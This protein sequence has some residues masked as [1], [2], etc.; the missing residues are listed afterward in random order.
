MIVDLFNQILFVPIF[1][2]LVWL[3][4]I[5]PG[6]DFGVAIIVLTL[7][8]R[9]L[10]Y[11]LAQKGIRS[12]KALSELQPQIKTVQQKYKNSKEKQAQELM[13]LYKERGVNPASGCLPLII[14]FP[15]LIALFQVLRRGLNPETLQFLYPLVQNPQT[16]NPMFLGLINLAVGSIFL[17]VLAGLTQFVQSKMILPKKIPGQQTGRSDFASMMSKQMVYTMPVITV[18]I[19]A[20]FPAGLALYWTV[21]N[22]FTIFQQYLIIKKKKNGE[23]P[24]KTN[25]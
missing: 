14:Q 25:N 13:K 6:G 23:S 4:N 5:L 15:I 21:N 16:I 18:L 8:V 1:N 11:P 7:V 19:A 2:F 12:Q 22:L 10:L 3:Y 20:R 9:L 24:N 17:A